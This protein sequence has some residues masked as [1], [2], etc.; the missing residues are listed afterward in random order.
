MEPE[1]TKA[2]RRLRFER[3][4][5]L[6]IILLLAMGMI[7]TGVYGVFSPDSDKLS[8]FWS[9][10]TGAGS[11]VYCLNYTGLALRRGWREALTLPL[12]GVWLVGAAGWLVRMLS[13][14]E[15]GE[16]LETVVGVLYLVCL[17]VMVIYVLLS[18][19]GIRTP[20]DK[21]AE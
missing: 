21:M 19:W 10:L 16:T 8:D 13:Y 17:P 20:G 12:C 5:G 6:P 18:Y 1:L 3:R 9:I 15:T 11:A 7:A 14:D 2:E 4:Y